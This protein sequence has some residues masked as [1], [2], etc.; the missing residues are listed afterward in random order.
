MTMGIAAAERCNDFGWHPYGRIDTTLVAEIAQHPRFGMGHAWSRSAEYNLT[1]AP[2]RIYLVLTMEGGFEFTVDGEDVTAEPGSLI[3]LDGAVP[4]TARTFTETARF[5]WHLEPTMLNP[6][7]SRFRFGE[8]I[9][10]GGTSVEAL[11]AVTNTLLQAPPPATELARHHLASSLE[12]ILVAVVE[13]S[14]HR[15]HGAPH[16]RDGLFMAALT[17]IGTRFRDPAFNVARLA[18][19]LSI[20]ERP[21]HHAFHSMGTT[22]RREIERRRVTEANHLAAASPPPM[23]TL[24]ELAARSG[25]TST[26]QLTRA[27]A[28]AQRDQ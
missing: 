8:P 10:T 17:V 3:V 13:E 4:T 5:V 7:Q 14:G 20:S 26:Q 16:H 25:F 1:T 15:Q 23:S 12:N 21:L 11:T 9:P 18:R 2:E 27:L 22:P 19:E 6:A 28:R 24:R